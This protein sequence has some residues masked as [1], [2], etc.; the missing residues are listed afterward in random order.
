MIYVPAGEFEMGSMDGPDDEQPVHAV[1][2]DGFWFDQW[3][4]TNG[5]YAQCVAAGV[6]DPP[7]AVSSHTRQT[8]YGDEAFD[9]YPVVYVTRDKADAYCTWAEARLPTEAEWEYAARG[10]ESLRYPWGNAFDGTRLNYCDANCDFA[11]TD[12]D[13]D[14]GYADTAPV[15]SYPTGRS[16]CEAQ[17]MAG[18]AWEWVADWYDGEYYGHS[19]AENPPGPTSG[20]YAVA[21]GGSWNND[22]ID[23]RAPMRY[24][25][26]PDVAWIDTGFRCARDA[27]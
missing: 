8:Y 7:E 24:Y 12:Q 21:R 10:P 3:E 4:V 19:P 25:D 14:D 6:C 9:D 17:D 15:G 11:W 23:V 13:V 16:W 2:L 1:R 5:Q 20:E 27:E 18:N 26:R 22:K